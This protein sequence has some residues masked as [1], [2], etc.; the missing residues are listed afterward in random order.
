MSTKS[1]RKNVLLL[2]TTKPLLG[3]TRD[4][5]KNKPAQYKLY[6]FTKGG[7]DECDQRVESYSTKPKSRKWTIVAFCYV[8]DMARINS[9]TIVALNK[10]E[11]PR[12]STVTS[13]DIGWELSRALVAPFIQARPL[14]GLTRSTILKTNLVIGEKNMAEKRIQPV[15]ETTQAKRKRCHECMD[16]ITGEGQKT[17]KN[18]LPKMTSVCA[19]CNTVFCKQ[20]LTTLCRNCSQ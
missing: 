15:A 19:N 6:D 7:T 11:N 17:E 18:K 8:L 10:N 12:K 1:G 5:N 4:D 14:N 9:G 2:A 16:Q 13:F 20:H 3:V